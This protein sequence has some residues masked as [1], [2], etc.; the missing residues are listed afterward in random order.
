MRPFTSL[1][2]CALLLASCT[3]AR[4]TGEHDACSES[5]ADGAVP[6]RAPDAT[7]LV[8]RYALAVVA[9]NERD[10]G[11]TETG[12][13]RLW[14]PGSVPRFNIP[15]P[16]TIVDSTTKDGSVTIQHVRLDLDSI[17]AWH[18]STERPLFGTAAIALTR[19]GV[20]GEVSPESADSTRPGVVLDGTTLLVGAHARYY[21]VKQAD[22]VGSLSL[23][24]DWSSPTGF[25]GSW[26][27]RYGHNV[28]DSTGRPVQP[29]SGRFCARLLSSGDSA[30]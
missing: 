5:P 28:V 18:P 4:R 30:T 29:A 20:R 15:E 26:R 16:L 6:F 12:E 2:A 23:H 9:T 27:A 14:V 17:V 19:F 3:A 22:G 1:I 8:G 24:V 10:R 11:I 13:L 25:G 7:D 21:G